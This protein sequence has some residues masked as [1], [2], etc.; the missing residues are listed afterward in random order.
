MVTFVSIN[1]FSNARDKGVINWLLQWNKK[2]EAKISSYKRNKY[3]FFF[4]LML[5][6]Y[7]FMALYIKVPEFKIF[8]YA[9]FLR[10]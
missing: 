5:A 10:F 3:D 1:S 9:G 7:F 6:C 8:K 2:F 4:F